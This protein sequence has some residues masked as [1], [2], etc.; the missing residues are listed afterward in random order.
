MRRK[1]VTGGSGN[2]IEPVLLTVEEGSSQRREHRLILALSL[3]FAT[4]RG[5]CHIRFR[6]QDH[7]RDILIVEGIRHRTGS[8]TSNQL[9]TRSGTSV[10]ESTMQFRWWSSVVEC[11]RGIRLSEEGVPEAKTPVHASQ[12]P[13]KL[14]PCL[15]FW[16][17]LAAGTHQQR[18]HQTDR[19]VICK[20]HAWRCHSQ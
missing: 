2:A 9:G 4:F 20:S 5:R 6:R 13:P 19:H 16:L 15:V 18:H 1:T 11:S 8:S 17:A 3:Y 14:D 12:P 7:V 10:G